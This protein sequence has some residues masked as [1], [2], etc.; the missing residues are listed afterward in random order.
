MENLHPE[1]T[2]IRPSFVF[3]KE[4]VN[5]NPVIGVEIGVDRGF[6]SAM[7][8]TQLPTLTLYCVDPYERMYTHI[9]GTDELT[10]ENVIARRNFSIDLLSM[11]GEERCKRVFKHSVE[12]AKDFQDNYFD[13]IYIDAD[14]HYQPIKADLDAWYPKLK[15]GG[16]FGGHD[17]TLGCF[18]VLNAVNE[19]YGKKGVQFNTAPNGDFWSVKEK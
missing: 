17:Y 12:A 11:F 10:R 4:S 16:V 13:Y 2:G 5:G 18:G 1:Q 3:F 15:V 19:F 6:N 9:N 7:M 14:H 8:L